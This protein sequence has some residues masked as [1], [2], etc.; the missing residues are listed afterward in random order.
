MVAS[1]L[2]YVLPRNRT[3]RITLIIWDVGALPTHTLHSMNGK[4]IK[5]IILL[6]VLPSSHAPQ[7]ATTDHPT[8]RVPRI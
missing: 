1:V 2:S 5:V 4:I 3:V 8:H 6:L 7:T